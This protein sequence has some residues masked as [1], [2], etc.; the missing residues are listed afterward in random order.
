M[1]VMAKRGTVLVDREALAMVTGRS[2]H[3]IRLRCPVAGYR[4][5]R[6]LYDLEREV[7]RL[8]AIRTRRRPS[9]R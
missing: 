8:A 1:I 5:G 7:E 6:A 3:T 4:A 9:S 2:I